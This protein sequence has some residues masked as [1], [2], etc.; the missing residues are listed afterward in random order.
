MMTASNDEGKFHSLA[1]GHLYTILGVYKIKNMKSSNY[2][3]NKNDRTYK[4]YWSRK[5]G[6]NKH[7]KSLHHKFF[8]GNTF[9]KIIC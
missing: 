1:V 8:L 4:D 2:H 9:E 6:K 5:C 7:V 3:Y